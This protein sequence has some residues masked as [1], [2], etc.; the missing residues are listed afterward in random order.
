MATIQ[1]AFFDRT[2]VIGDS[3]EI[4]YLVFDAAAEDAVKTLCQD[5][6]NIPATYDSLSLKE[7]RLEERVNATTWRV[8]AMY[9]KPSWSWPGGSLPDGRYAFDT[10]G[11]SQ[12]ITQSIAT[13]NRYGPKASES[14]GGAIGFDGKN[15]QG[16]DITVPVF[17]FSE[18]HYFTDEEITGEYKRTLF[19][20]TGK[21]NNGTFRGFSPKEVLFLGAAG[22]RQGNADTDL[23]EIVFRFAASPNLTDLV[24]GEITGIEKAGWDY[25]W[26]QYADAADETT[27][28]V[29][30]H[31]VAVYVEQVYYPGDLS[32]LAIGTE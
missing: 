1:E 17:N 19:L 27:Q 24:I 16:C 15:V 21:V 7:I 11:G 5:T 20:L 32:G 12:H 2:E 23:W 6:D 14:L 18:T 8:T 9:R 31:P 28:Q 4:P 25:L 13:V 10:G 26:I 3:A 22:S 30:K 29:V